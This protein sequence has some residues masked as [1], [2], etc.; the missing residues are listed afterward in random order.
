MFFRILQKDLK[1][2]KTMNIIIFLFVILAAMF[3]ASSV[4]NILTVAN[5]LDYYF[6]KA[7]LTQD[8]FIL[9]RAGEET[10]DKLLTAEPSVETYQTEPQIMA[11]K[12]NFTRGGE[13]SFQFDSAGLI[14]S[15][16][17][18][19]LNYFDADNNVITEVGQGEVYITGSLL[20]NSSLNPGDTIMLDHSGTELTLTIAGP[21]KDALLGSEFIGNPR[22]LVH[23]DDYAKLME[24]ET[25]R[26]SYLTNIYY[27]YTDDIPALREA[28]SD[29]N[30]ILFDAD[31][32]L[33]RMTYVMNMIVAGVLL[34][35]S[36]GLILVSFTVL[37]FTIGFTIAEEFREIGVMK[38]MGIGSLAIRLLYLTK[39]LGIAVAGAAVG[40]AASVPFG[41]LLLESVSESMVLGSR[42][43]LAVGLVCSVSVVL[44]ILFFCYSCTGR[45]G[46]LSPI[47]A[48]RNGQTGERFGKKSFLHLEKS[49]LGTTGFLAVSDIASSPRQYGIIT[50]VFSICLLIVMIL[51]N[52]A[53][54]LCSDKLLPL[55]GMTYSDAYYVDADI[56]V[57]MLDNS[58]GDEIVYETLH[59]IEDTLSDNG[60]PAKCVIET[61]YKYS[62]TFGG[63][64]VKLTFQQGKGTQANE[65]V[66]HEGMAPS[67]K[68]EI[69]LT[70]QA[71]ELIGAHIGDVVSINIGGEER[72]YMITAYFS[73]FNQ[74]GEF[75]RLHEDAETNMYESSGSMSIQVNFTDQPDSEEITRRIERM[76]D[77]FETERIHTAA[78]YVDINTGVSDT[79][80]AIDELVLVTTLIIA[81]LVTV[82]MERSFIA[83]DEGEIALMKA[84]GFRS[85]NII[86][87]H[88]LRFCLTVIGSALLA[89][90][91]CIPLTKLC[92][93]PIFHLIGSAYG[94]DYEIKPL[95]LFLVYPLAMLTVTVISAFLTSLCT[96]AITASQTSNIE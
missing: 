50:I 43:S 2:K 44:L 89:S 60:M 14:L 1:R 8:Y 54:T 96:K 11:S 63:H 51:S 23:P 6:E 76:K 67:A 56:I 29:E 27:I 91:L 78:E 17:N 75:G 48:V 7:G 68:N 10:L 21:A 72:D 22:F 69:A 84:M 58:T 28:V 16:E 65:Y 4:N 82:L 73:C 83:M 52:T 93:D 35:V 5:G 25:V 81:A 92:I 70:P 20:K 74:L 36:I 19:Q 57:E 39:Y 87:Q 24:N 32:S 55:L 40:F 12:G 94:I 46:R 64:S 30:G 49:R 71:A 45:I 41:N 42:N 26:Q 53:N 62:V 15:I 90:A 3:V 77:I 47:D 34:V 59:E 13:P 33:I 66:Y 38:A 18:A 79:V 88:T 95:E 9:A 85:R 61:Q 80:R 31:I 86:A 37:R